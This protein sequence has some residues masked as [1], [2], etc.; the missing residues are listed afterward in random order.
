[1]HAQSN[2]ALRPKPLRISIIIIF[3]FLSPW[4]D[5]SFHNLLIFPYSQNCH[6]LIIYVYLI[7]DKLDRFERKSVSSIKSVIAGA[8]CSN[9]KDS[10]LYLLILSSYYHKYNTLSDCRGVMLLHSFLLEV[11]PRLLD[12]SL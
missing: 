3:N 6:H 2:I 5:C 4:A 8:Y 7:T 1:M 9:S 12:S 10:A 11:N